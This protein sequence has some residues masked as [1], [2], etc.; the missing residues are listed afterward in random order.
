MVKKLLQY[1]YPRRRYGPNK[2]VHFL[3]Y[4]YLR[5]KKVY[6]YN[7][8]MQPTIFIHRQIKFRDFFSLFTPIFLPLIT[9]YKIR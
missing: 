9:A 1:L 2:L 3:S 5:N 8:F 6:D 7:L 4:S